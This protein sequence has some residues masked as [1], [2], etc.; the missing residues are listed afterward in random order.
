MKLGY[1]ELMNEDV[2]LDY[3]FAGIF[4][5]MNF[6]GIIFLITLSISLLYNRQIN[7]LWHNSRYTGQH[8]YYK[9]FDNVNQNLLALIIKLN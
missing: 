6:K 3:F 7:I 4:K 8:Y 1:E 9:S 5:G 2:Q